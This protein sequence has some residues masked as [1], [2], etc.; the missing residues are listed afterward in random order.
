VDRK[1]RLI[2]V[3]PV[4]PPIHG[5]AV[6]TLLAL[7][8]PLLH[9]AFEIEHLD[10]TDRRPLSN[11]GKWDF[12]NVVLGLSA[13]AK[14]CWKLRSGRGMVYLPLSENR[15]G[16]LRDSLF[17]H[18]SALRGWKVAVHIRNSLFRRFYDPQPRLFKWWINLTFRRMSGL[19]VLGEPLRALFV[20]LFPAE[21]IAV[22]QNGTTAFD[23]H[24]VEPN[25]NQ[26][27]YLSNFHRKKGVDWAVE[28]ALLVL[29]Q[30]PETR[31]VF[32][33]E[34]ESPEVER[35]LRALADR[36]NGAITFLPP[37]DGEAKRRLMASSS[38][39]LFPVAWGEGHP[40]ILLEA[41]AAG[42]PVVTTDRATISDTVGDGEAGFVLSD[43]DPQHLADR[44]LILL[45]DRQL[46]ANMSH[47]AK[48]RYLERFTQAHADKALAR[49]LG[50]LIDA[51][52]TTA[53]AVEPR[54]RLAD[55][56]TRE[57]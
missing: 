33:G 50:G 6:S 13:L 44:I 42:L 40:R 14:L 51:N 29:S 8:N 18:A 46:R 36:G 25:P 11:M 22:V 55:D 56:K 49:W 3:G 54:R 21:E 32:A 47:T 12:R 2:I 53:R 23:A 52:V 24:G 34:W 28:T 4:P 10:T 39:L 30:R 5:V 15:G 17:I 35:E 48:L 19:A 37:V 26:V 7:E 43:P 31:F 9:A 16:F 57:W 41:L 20:G 27:L 45:R 1:P 38:V